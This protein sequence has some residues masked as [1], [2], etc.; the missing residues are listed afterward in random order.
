[1]P[2]DRPLGWLSLGRPGGHLSTIFSKRS[3][4]RGPGGPIYGTPPQGGTQRTW[5]LETVLDGQYVYRCGRRSRDMIQYEQR[6]CSLEASRRWKASFLGMPSPRISAELLSSHPVYIDTVLSSICNQSWSQCQRD[7]MLKTVPRNNM[8]LLLTHIFF[9]R[10]WAVLGNVTRGMPK[11]C[12]WRIWCHL[13]P[14]LACAL[15]Q[16]IC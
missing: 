12:H 2:V 15:R 11:V 3:V 8:R 10:Q 13:H 7:I 6:R 5:G 14:R 1:M 16:I 4:E 9:R